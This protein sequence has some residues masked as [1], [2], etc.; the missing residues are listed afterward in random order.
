MTLP[1]GTVTFLFSDIEGSTELLR[2][3]GEV[4]F[5]AVRADHRRLLR[6]AFAANGGHEIDTAGDG[7]FVAFESTRSAV[8]AAIAAQR[9]LAAFTW[10][11]GAA[12]RVRI[13]IHT[14]EPHL[15]DEGYV[16]LGVHRAARI[17]FAAR[18][19]QI[20]ISNS[21]AGIIEDAE[22]SGV[23]LR[24]L[25][26]HRLKGNPRVQRLFQLTVHGLQSKFDLPRT[27]DG[28]TQGPGIATFLMTDLVGFRRIVGTLG[29]EESAAIIADYQSIVDAAVEIN[30]GFVVDRAGDNAWAVFGSAGDAVR[31]AAAFREA[32]AD[33]AWPPECDVSASVVIHSGRWSGDRRRPTAGT[34]FVRLG[35][36]ARFV[37]PGQILVSQATVSLLEGDRSVPSLRDLGDRAISDSD[38]PTRIYEL[39]DSP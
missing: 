22:V 7:F 10:P 24:D 17:C 13:G 20:L 4:A 18:G 3:V 27:A 12:V 14:A 16:G 2:R 1:R 11:A 38:R 31:A 9:S 5:A 6:D 34:A 36:F 29:D 33:F 15:G 19:G 26:E 30:H 28:A 32:F 21:T 25:G 39:G 23:E 37:Q 35:E 8:A